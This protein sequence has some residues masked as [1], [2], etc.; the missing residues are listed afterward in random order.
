MQLAVH[1]CTYAKPIFSN[2]NYASNIDIDFY[3]LT[4]DQLIDF[5]STN[6]IDETLLLNNSQLFEKR[7]ENVDLYLLVQ[8]KN[9]GDLGAWG[10]V[11]CKT[12]NNN[13]DLCI[14]TGAK[15]QWKN[16]ILQIDSLVFPRKDETVPSISYEWKELNTK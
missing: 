4:K 12:K 1:F 7:S 13:F 15:G 9:N 2:E 6:K 5:L 8:I 14:T 10:M 16:Y 3:F 11:E